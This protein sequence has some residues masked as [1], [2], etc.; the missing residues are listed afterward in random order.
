MIYFKYLKIH[1]KKLWQ[2]R[3]SL[4]LSLISQTLTSAM[5]ILTIYFLFDRFKIVDGWT[6]QQVSLSY[7]VSYLCFSFVECFFRGIDQFP[8]LIKTGQLDSFLIRP[9]SILTQ[10]ICADVEFSKIGRLIVG[11]AVLI[12]SCVIQPFAFTPLKVLV[13][14]LMIVCGIVVFLSL[15]LIGAAVSVFTIDGIEAMN[16]LTD[17]GRELCQYPVNIYGEFVKN[18]FTFIVPFA[19]F[20]YL[21]MQ[22]L[23]NMP[24]VSVWGNI[25]TPLYGFLF[26]IPAV[27]F[28]NLSLKKYTSTGT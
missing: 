24:N 9:R 1:F 6:F 4:L 16:I 26:F 25:L 8:K 19:C 11:M 3:L 18:F 17:G 12:Y 27:I 5:A 22:F 21:P 13:L 10:A 2:Y 14:M 28:F 20:N 23:F 15:F 7:A